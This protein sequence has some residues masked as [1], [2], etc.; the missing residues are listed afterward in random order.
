[1][2]ISPLNFVGVSTY[3]QDFQTILSRA[4]QIA[5]LP[6]QQ[7]QNRDSDVLQKKT[8]LS[9]LSANVSSLAS[10]LQA[11]GS[12]SEN[13]AL[14]A[15]SSNTA[16][17]TV[18][19]TG[20]TTA[21]TYVIDSITSTAA[22][23]SERTQTGYADSAA[24]PV[25]STGDLKLVVG[26]NEYD[27]S[28]TNNTLVGLRD[29]INTLGAGVTASILTT[30][31]GNYLSISA[32]NTGATTLALYDDPTGVNTNLLT[33]TN[34]GTNA[35]FSLNGI[36]V[37]Q[38]TNLVNSVIPGLTLT[39]QEAT[40]SPVT[41]QLATSK[42]SLSSALQD[43]VSK[44]NTLR[45][46]VNA[47]VGPS[48]GLLS[49]DLLVNQ[50][51]G[52]LRQIA[53]YRLDGNAISSLA[54][55]GVEFS[56]SGV[57]SFNSTTFNGLSDSQVNA[58]F[59]YLGTASTGF[60]AFSSNLTQFSDPISGLI[61]LEQDGLDATD[62]QLQDQISKITDRINV[63]QLGLQKKLQQADTL[64][65]TLESQQTQLTASLA[66]LSYVMFGKK[67]E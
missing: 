6:I 13:K 37:S 52:Q 61:K 49:G 43:F 23:A 55:L 59:D 48:A 51:Q 35:V 21:A 45:D 47:Q 46:A 50:L 40:A 62:V 34:Q 31:D 30:A 27:F 5:Q 64:L 14:T 33:N 15:T 57:A 28:L 54:D 53:G 18:S 12:T 26:A 41:L 60:G 16:A 56:N 32:N 25:S 20:A 1:M 8:L 19:N 42:S 44:Y 17:V 36:P 2:G 24:T 65:A 29:K 3:S 9:S 38:S 7:L 63:M 66:S 10:S 67:A 39:I 58:A 22:A 11:L 4:V